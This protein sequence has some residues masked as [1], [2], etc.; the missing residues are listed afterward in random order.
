[1]SDLMERLAAANPVAEDR[2]P[3]IEDVWDKIDGARPARRAWR[4]GGR[5]LVIAAVAL[6]VIGVLL[7]AVTL[8][9]ADRRGSQRTATNVAPGRST[10][11]P[12]LQGAALR[13]LAGRDGAI[14]V[15]DPRTGA[16][17]ALAAGRGRS[18][19]LWAPE[20]TFDVVT[21]AAALDRG[22]YS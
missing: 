19:T 4:A 22:R 17:E 14:V 8:R 1:M 2:M 16:V 10:L 12:A 20:A 7:V 6:P 18:G 11:D 13:Q 15:V 3:S 9:G 21:A 5:A